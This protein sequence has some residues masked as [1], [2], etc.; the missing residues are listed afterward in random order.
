MPPIFVWTSTALA[1]IFF[2]RLNS[3]ESASHS[4][5]TIPRRAVANGGL[6]VTGVE[7]ARS[8]SFECVLFTTWPRFPLFS[9]GDQI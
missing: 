9:Q 8:A 6:S 1:K 3:F 4:S 7:S 5:T 2:I